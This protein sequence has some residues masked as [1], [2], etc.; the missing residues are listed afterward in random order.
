M[1]NVI[2]YPGIEKLKIGDRLLLPTSFHPCIAPLVGTVV[3]I[4]PELHF[5]TA[6]FAF[7]SKRIRESY[8]ALGRWD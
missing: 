1:D 8:C 4:H 5:F 2:G 6:E 7:G 3:Y